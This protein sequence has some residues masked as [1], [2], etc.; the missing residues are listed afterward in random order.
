MY[1]A[2]GLILPGKQVLYVEG[3]NLSYGFL[4]FRYRFY[5][6]ARSYPTK[7]IKCSPVKYDLNETQ[8][9][10]T[11]IL[12]KGEAEVIPKYAKMDIRNS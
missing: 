5:E 11:C 3:I 9:G 8:K 12:V 6:I 10:E 7:I 1:R 4:D 2:T